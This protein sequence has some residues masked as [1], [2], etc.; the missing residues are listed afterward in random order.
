MSSG[1]KMCVLVFPGH[2]SAT[3][4]AHANPVGKTLACCNK[5]YNHEPGHERT[6]RCEQ[7]QQQQREP[8]RRS[9][10]LTAQQH[11]DACGASFHG[12]WWSLGAKKEPAIESSELDVNDIEGRASTTTLD[13]E[14]KGWFGSSKKIAKGEDFKGKG[15]EAV[16]AEIEPLR[17]LLMAYTEP[18]S[19]CVICHETFTG[20]HAPERSLSKTDRKASTAGKELPCCT[21]RVCPDCYYTRFRNQE[22]RGALSASTAPQCPVCKLSVCASAKAENY[23]PDTWWS[24]SAP[25]P[26][27]SRGSGALWRESWENLSA[28]SRSLWNLFVRSGDK[29]GEDTSAL[30]IDQKDGKA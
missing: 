16:K 2:T 17:E 25:A 22:S 8:A 28:G 30:A 11:G 18:T 12:S 23:I 20:M 27:S 26:G 5:K 19:Y 1:R 21:S 24:T 7:Q 9:G 14:K 29:K 3:N 15:K 6:Y 10:N 4:I 13:Q